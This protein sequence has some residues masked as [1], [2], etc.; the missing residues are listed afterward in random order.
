[1]IVLFKEF[2]APHKLLLTLIVALWE[3]SPMLV[4]ALE[5]DILIA[6]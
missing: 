3:L 6:L 1:M 5:I 2:H 4:T